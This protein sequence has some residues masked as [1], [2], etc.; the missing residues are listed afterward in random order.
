MQ[1]IVRYRY[2]SSDGIQLADLPEPVPGPGEVLVRV[3]AVSLNT[4]DVE[5]LTGRPL[6]ARVFGFFRPRFPVL[7][8]DL[9]GVVQAVGAGVTRFR[10]GDEVLGDILGSGG[11]LA[12]LALAQ[13]K[14][15]LHKPSALSFAEAACLPQAGAIAYQG[16]VRPGR[17]AV[18]LR[19]R[20][21]LIVGAGGGSGSIAIQL[22]KGLGAEVTGVDNADK[23]S[24]MRELGADRTLDYRRDDFTRGPGAYDLI[25]DL[26]GSRSLAEI[27]PVL[28]PGGRY[29]IVGGPVRRILAA[30]VLG[31]LFGRGGRRF[32]MLAV[33]P[34]L[35]VEELIEQVV[36]GSV[37]LSIGGRYPLARAREAIDAVATGHALGKLVIE[38]P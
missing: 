32:G 12:E 24:L 26:V 7:G 30:G 21:V 1:A 37:R 3:R 4:S 15:L 19:D 16:I 27:S 38:L 10:P 14:C 20:R 28:A 17:G 36:A 29:W 6:Y 5:F 11:T 25:L 22:A 23:Q 8:T 31:F 33:Q 34:K 2:G 18:G 35:G 9:A 13:D